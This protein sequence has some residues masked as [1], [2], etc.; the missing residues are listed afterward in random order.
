MSSVKASA[1]QKLHEAR[2]RAGESVTRASAA[3]DRAKSN[4]PAPIQKAVDEKAG[5]AVRQ[6]TEKAKPYRWQAVALG[7]ILIGLL[8]AVRWRKSRRGEVS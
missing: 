6:R 8:V 2:E 3:V 1:N 7:A 4:V 5:P